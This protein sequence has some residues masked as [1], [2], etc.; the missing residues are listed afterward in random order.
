MGYHLLKTNW[1]LVEPCHHSES[2]TPYED[3]DAL[4]QYYIFQFNFGIVSSEAE[5]HNVWYIEKQLC[6]IVI[7]NYINILIAILNI[8]HM[9]RYRTIL[10]LV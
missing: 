1:L 9:N 3:Y 6:V 7:I 2:A 4:F 5:T 8:Y 10:G